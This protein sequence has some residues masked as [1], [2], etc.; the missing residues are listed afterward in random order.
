MALIEAIKYYAEAILFW[1]EYQQFIGFPFAT[2][3][4]DIIHVTFSVTAA[5]SPLS[6]RII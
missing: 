3:Q 1:F 6:A 2:G 4:L 5:T